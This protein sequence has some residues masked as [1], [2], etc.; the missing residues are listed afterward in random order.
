MFNK[1]LTSLSLTSPLSVIIF[2]DILKLLGGII[3]P[4]LGKIAFLLSSTV[5]E[6]LTS[7]IAGSD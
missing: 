3:L 1:A 2:V 5:I 4:R 6:K 7:F